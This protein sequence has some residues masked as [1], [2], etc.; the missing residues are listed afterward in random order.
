MKLNATDGKTTFKFA[1]RVWSDRTGKATVVRVGDDCCVLE[2]DVGRLSTIDNE[3]I[4]LLGVDEQT[5]HDL[6]ILTNNGL[7]TVVINGEALHG[8]TDI[9]FTHNEGSLP[10]LTVTKLLYPWDDVNEDE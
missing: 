1:D 2:D 4:T 5:V 3:D 9:M 8:V 7:T 6:Q 10:K